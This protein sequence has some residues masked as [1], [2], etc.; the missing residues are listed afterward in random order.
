MSKNPIS[1]EKYNQGDFD[2]YYSM[3]KEDQVMRYITGKGL[4]KEEALSKFKEII[5]FNLNENHMGY[6]KIYNNKDEFIGDGKLEWY[7]QDV[8]KLE[9]GYILKE[10]FWGRGY[11]TM[12]CREMLAL[13]ERLWPARD[14]I[15]IIDPDNIASRRLLEK[16]G[17]KSFFIGIEDDLPTEKLMLSK[18]IR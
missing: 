14:V 12:I 3:V 8:S 15:G 17:F 1:I 10:E 6:F 18:S 7:K 9:V 4:T 11:G 16:F 5:D 2:L 13:A